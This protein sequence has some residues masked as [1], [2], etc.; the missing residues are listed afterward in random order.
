MTAPN[1]VRGPALIDYLCLAEQSL[2][3]SPRFKK[4]IRWHD[5]R[6]KEY[7]DCGECRMTLPFHLPNCPVHAAYLEAEKAKAEYVRPDW[8]CSGCD[9]PKEGPHRFSCY[10]GGPRASQVILPATQNPDGT[11]SIDPPYSADNS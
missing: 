3:E 6:D 4:V 8:M 2:D 1:Q 7:W 10:V 11:F 9:Q 5:C